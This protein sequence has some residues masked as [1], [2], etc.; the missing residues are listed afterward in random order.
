MTM[1]NTWNTEHSIEVSATAETIWKIFRDVDNWKRWNSGI[2]EITIEGP[3][4]SG[5]WFT[6]KPP[7]EEAMRAQL[8]EVKENERFIDETHLGDIV[9]QVI[10][11]LNPVGAARTQVIYAVEVT[12]LGADEI[13]QAIS[14]DFP[15][16]LT[17]LAKLAKQ[18][19]AEVNR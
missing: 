12:G 10:H 1:K 9:V 5:T 4:I 11:Q 13:G 8:V 18:Q 2:E 14:A 16:V 7:F 15:D 3:F 17:S 6:M 19:S